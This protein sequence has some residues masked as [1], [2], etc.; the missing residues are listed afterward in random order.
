MERGYR[1]ATPTPTPPRK[2]GKGSARVAVRG[3]RVVG[4]VQP[5]ADHRPDLLQEG[6]QPKDPKTRGEVSKLQPR[7]LEEGEA[8]N[9]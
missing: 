8:V 3:T 7:S 4:A 5:G 1:G 2:R 9:K 6:R